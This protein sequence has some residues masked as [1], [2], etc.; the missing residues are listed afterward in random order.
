MQVGG[1]P[2][3]LVHFRL[4]QAVDRA[5]WPGAEQPRRRLGEQRRGIRHFSE[6]PTAGGDAGMD[7]LSV[8]QEL[9][10]PSVSSTRSANRAP[11]NR[12][13]ICLPSMI[14]PNSSPAQPG[15]DT[16]HGRELDAARDSIRSL[17]PPRAEPSFIP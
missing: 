13:G 4:E 14:R 10:W 16:A 1:G 3:L 6:I 15:D 2:D 7:R 8:D 5:I 11:D 17:C 12:A 9:A